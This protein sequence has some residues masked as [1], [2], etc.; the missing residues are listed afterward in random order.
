MYGLV[1]KQHLQEYLPAK[2]ITLASN[3]KDEHKQNNSAL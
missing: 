3:E 1:F 2:N